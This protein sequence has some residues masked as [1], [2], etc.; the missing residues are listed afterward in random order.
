M[1]AGRRR[2]LLWGAAIV[3][4]AGSAGAGAWVG[5]SQDDAS[6]SRTS[7]RAADEA[8]ATVAERTLTSQTEVDATLGY[9]GDYSIV[10]QAQG[11]VT[12]LPDVGSV[13]REGHALYRVD[14]TPVPL[15]YGRTPAYRSLAEGDTGRDVRQLNRALVELGYDDTGELDRTSD[16]YGWATREAVEN[17]QDH[18]DLDVTGDLPLGSVVFL[19]TAARITQ[20]TAVVGSP[21][22]VGQPIMTATSTDH[23][24]SLDL[25][26]S[27]QS[28]VKVGD[29][30]TIT[31]PDDSTT[32]GVVTDI[33]T[34]AATPDAPSES[35]SPDA[36]AVGT[37][38]QDATI[39]VL[40][41]PKR[42][43][44]L[45]SLDQAPVQVSITTDSQADALVVPVAALLAQPR[46]RYAVDVVDG[47]GRHR[48]VEV[49]LGLV[50]DASGMVAVT[51]RLSAGD[52]VV[53]PRS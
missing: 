53:V 12:W 19:P 52:H 36:A 7:S 22:P 8:T 9:A 34:V 11:T 42:P 45:G 26:V 13:V 10:N 49:K 18:L 43:R 24:I 44:R 33:S 46:G 29:A 47:A 23:Q 16:E 21:L 38:N 25:D 14:G 48:L 37:D 39:Q 2:G 51:G 5:T 32:T 30:V 17:L 20:E 28:H 41:A 50:D 35:S 15:L 4:L 3:V 1:T 27:L 31:L 6:P 40:I